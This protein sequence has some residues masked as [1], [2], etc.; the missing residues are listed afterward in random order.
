MRFFNSLT[1]CL[2]KENISPSSFERSQKEEANGSEWWA[3]KFVYPNNWQM[4]SM[5]K[6]VLKPEYKSKYPILFFGPE[7]LSKFI[8][9]FSLL[10]VLFLYFAN[11]FLF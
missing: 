1:I 8:L 6:V 2:N 11:K 10:L 5:K 9:T 3:D 4:N 7:N